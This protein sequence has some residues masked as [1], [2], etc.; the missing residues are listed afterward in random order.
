VLSRPYFETLGDNDVVS[1]DERRRSP[2]YTE[3]YDP[4]DA[5]FV[6]MARLP[7]PRGA[8][9]VVVSLRSASVGHLVEEDRLRFAMLLPHVAAAVRLQNRLDGH[10]QSLVTGAL[11]AVGLPAFLLSASG[12]VV[13]LTASA[14]IFAGQA[15]VLQLRSRKIYALD[16]Y[17]NEQLQGA[18]RRA[19]RWSIEPAVP[20]TSIVLRGESIATTVEVAQLPRAAGPSR[21]GAVAIVTVQQP[22][23]SAYSVAA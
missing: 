3:L 12:C 14:E 13:G 18:I 19:C 11:D 17:G 5:P 21:H 15:G 4:A 23:K 9:V 8:S 2:F 16:R 20:S 1:A 10:G 6:C 22:P 7:A